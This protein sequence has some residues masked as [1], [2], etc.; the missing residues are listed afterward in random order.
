MDEVPPLG[1]VVEQEALVSRPEY[2]PLRLHEPRGHVEELW[3]GSS[4]TGSC[5]G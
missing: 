5:H 1:L 4:A 3:E 2:D